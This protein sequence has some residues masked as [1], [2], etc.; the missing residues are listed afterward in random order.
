MK[1]LLFFVLILS[2]CNI[3]LS[4]RQLYIDPQTNTAVY[5]AT[6]N[7]TRRT[8]GDCIIEANKTCPNGFNIVTSSDRTVGSLSSLNLNTSS[9][10]NLNGSFTGNTFNSNFSANSNT[11]G[12]GYNGLII[13]RNLIYSCK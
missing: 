7:G 13:T 3:G 12:L 5:E 6:C 2:G 11:N 10:G 1:K 9:S 4:N 8:I